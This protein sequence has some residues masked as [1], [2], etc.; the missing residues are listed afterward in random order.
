M[1]LEE[2]IAIKGLIFEQFLNLL[3]F[4]LRQLSIEPTEKILFRIL[5]GCKKN[6]LYEAFEKFREDFNK[7]ETEP[8]LLF[9]TFRQKLSSVV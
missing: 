4:S 9:D 5:D 8:T 7:E 6:G 2:D 1:T 3:V